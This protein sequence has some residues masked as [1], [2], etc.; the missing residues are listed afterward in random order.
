[1]D[2]TPP[3]TEHPLEMENKSCGIRDFHD[4]Q[5]GRLASQARSTVLFFRHVTKTPNVLEN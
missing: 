2:G 5:V 3:T 1:M 4:W